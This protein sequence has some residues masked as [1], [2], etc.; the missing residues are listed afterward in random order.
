ML[1]ENAGG[2]PGAHRPRDL[3]GA[4]RLRDQRCELY[5]EKPAPPEAAPATRAAEPGP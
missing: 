1:G 5:E 2:C 3:R 4:N